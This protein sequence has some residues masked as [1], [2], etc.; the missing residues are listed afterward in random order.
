MK[1][2]IINHNFHYEIEN[3]TRVFFPNEKIEIIKDTSV[4]E[5]EQPCIVTRIDDT[6][7]GKTVFVEIMLDDATKAL[8]HLLK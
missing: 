6:E 5:F 8:Q 1:I 3:L 2:Y 4:N 7:N